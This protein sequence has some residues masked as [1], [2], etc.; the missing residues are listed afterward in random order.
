M[1]A[2]SPGHVNTRPLRAILVF[3]LA[4]GYN[5]KSMNII[6]ILTFLI[7]LPGLKTDLKEL[8]NSDLAKQ[9]VL[10]GS[11]PFALTFSFDRPLKN[12]IQEN[13]KFDTYFDI[14]NEFGGKV[15]LAGLGLN[16]LV[17]RAV[18]DQKFRDFSYTAFE[19]AILAGITSVAI[20]IIIGR[21]RPSTSSSPYRFDPPGIDDEY[22]ALPSGHTT[23][24][25]A[26]LTVLANYYGENKF[27]KYGSYALAASTGLARVY[28]NRHWL[29]DCV[30]GAMLGYYFGKRLSQLHL[31]G[32]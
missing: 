5:L 13:L 27:I 32:G 26:W 21:A 9:V 18:D 19:S 30:M 6:L 1:V 22:Q 8:K 20:K 16:F 23:I 4:R 25:F 29:S 24:A 12:F 14:T 7:S 31:K 11:I 3:E 28:K 10:T 15:A 2:F 17:S